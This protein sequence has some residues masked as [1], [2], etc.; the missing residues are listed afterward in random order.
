[1]FSSFKL[2]VFLA[3]E[4]IL[5]LEWTVDSTLGVSCIIAAFPLGNK[6]LKKE[7]A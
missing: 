7:V 6:M 2:N 5:K 3:D 4:I 1:M